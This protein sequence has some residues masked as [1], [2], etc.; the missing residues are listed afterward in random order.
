[1]LVILPVMLQKAVEIS[2]KIFGGAS[3]LLS[4]QAHE[5]LAKALLVNQH[6]S[7]DQF[8]THAQRAYRIA[9]DLLPSLHPKFASY[10]MT[11]GQCC[12]TTVPLAHRLSFTLQSIYT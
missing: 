2:E 4:A 1:M 7:D 11:N 6:I 9:L 5:M 12:S 10:R 3:S 8:V